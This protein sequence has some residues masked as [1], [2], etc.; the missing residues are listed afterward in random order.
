MKGDGSAGMRKMKKSRK[1]DPVLRA[2]WVFIILDVLILSFVTVMLIQADAEYVSD[3]AGLRIRKEPST[4][5]EIVEV[6]PYGE[7]VHG[8]TKAGWMELDDGR[9]HVKAEFLSAE[10]PLDGMSCLG[11]RWLLTAYTHTGFCCAD[12]SYPEAGYTVA[13]NSLPLGTKVYISEIGIRTVCDRGPSSMPDEWLDLFVDSYEEAVIFGTE[14]H[15]VYLLPEE[16][17]EQ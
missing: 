8:T 6:L 9:G 17:E 15:K 3:Y 12:G 13:C 11:D 7:E 1:S 14:Y 4:E 2:I 5:A 10:D 16:G